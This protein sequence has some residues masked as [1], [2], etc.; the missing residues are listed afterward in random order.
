M[1]NYPKTA[2]SIKSWAEEDRPREKLILK[3]R[4]ALTDAE[5]VA[6]LI[7]S[8]NTKMSAVELSKVILNSVQND[9]NRLAKLS[10]SDF[11][12]FNGI[13]EACLLYTSDAADE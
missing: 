4:S 9:L 5:L 7:G 11:K 6:I 12:E 2:L 8:G 13:G 3:G 1:E 10:L